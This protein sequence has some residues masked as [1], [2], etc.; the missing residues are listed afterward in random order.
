MPAWLT[1][2]FFGIP[3]AIGAWNAYRGI[4]FVLDLGV[5]LQIAFP[6]MLSG[7]GVV[8]LGV[9]LV[10][11]HLEGNVSSWPA[12]R[13]RFR[14]FPIRGR[15]WLWVSGALALCV[16]SDALLE[17]VGKWL[18]TFPA[19]APPAYFPPP[20]NPTVELVLP[21]AEFLGVPFRGN[22]FIFWLWVPLSLVSMVGEEFLWRG[23]ILP[24]QEAGQGQWA[25]VVNGLLWALFFHVGMKW[26][27]VGLVPSS[28]I[29]AWIAQKLKNT[30]ASIVVHVGGNAVLFWGFL[31]VGVL[32]VGG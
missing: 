28:L 30:T 31:L 23:Y 10:A 11:Y 32:G 25:W 13:D 17:G 12:L 6:I 21:I 27:L 18:A 2:A 16:T 9:A 1:I 20:F 19:L 26:S 7:M 4:P 22:W 14:L 8:L 5:P 15:E 3:G 24:R 29:T